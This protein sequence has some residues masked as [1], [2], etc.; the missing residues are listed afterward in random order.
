MCSR[1]AHADIKRS[2]QLWRTCTT[3]PPKGDRWDFGDGHVLVLG[4]CK[5]CQTTLAKP[6]QEVRK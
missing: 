5:G 3:P 4:N 1:K 6:E 2:E